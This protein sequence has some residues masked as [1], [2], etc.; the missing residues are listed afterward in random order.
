MTTLERVLVG[1][2]VAITMS[3][4]IFISINYIKFRST[5]KKFKKLEQPVIYCDID[6]RMLY[7]QSH[8]PTVPSKV[9]R[10]SD[11]IT[12]LLFR[13]AVNPNTHRKL[14]G[15]PPYE[16]HK[17]DY[18]LKRVTATHYGFMC[19]AYTWNWGRRVRCTEWHDI[20]KKDFW[21]DPNST[22]QLFAKA[23]RAMREYANR[24]D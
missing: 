19:S 4:F 3:A 20:S 21:G 22:K 14:I 13:G 6:S 2:F 17:H 8:D 18:R 15:Y 1:V 16:G 5:S 12:E 23:V 7:I 24:D 9:T 11:D 10:H